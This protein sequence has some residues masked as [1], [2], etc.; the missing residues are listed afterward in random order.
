MYAFKDAANRS[1]VL[2]PEGTAGIARMFIE[3]NLFRSILP[4]KLFYIG[5]MF[6]YEKP[7]SGRQ[8]QFYQLGIEYLG[9][10]NIMADIEVIML[11]Y[12]LLR[13]VKPIEY[14]VSV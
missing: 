6:R 9:N 5:P 13:A 2:R 4:K 12:D 8:R 11:A 10:P 1:L 7:Q 3:K 14:T